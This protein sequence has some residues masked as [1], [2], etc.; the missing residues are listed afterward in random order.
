MIVITVNYRLTAYGYLYTGFVEPGEQTSGN[1]GFLDQQ[2]A[3]KWV[4]EN[5]AQFNGDPNKIMVY[6]QSAGAMSTMYHLCNEE[7]SKYFQRAAIQSFPMTIPMYK[8][9]EASIQG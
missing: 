4:H 8:S 2:A 3:I 9:F 7:S 6:G 1:W 5:I